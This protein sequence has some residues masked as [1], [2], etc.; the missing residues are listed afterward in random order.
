MVQVSQKDLAFDLSEVMPQVKNRE[1]SIWHLALLKKERH[2]ENT[3]PTHTANMNWLRVLEF[4]VEAVKSKAK[5]Q[6][7]QPCTPELVV[8]P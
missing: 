5:K 1:V 8:L 3:T 4:G 2:H 6:S 7:Q